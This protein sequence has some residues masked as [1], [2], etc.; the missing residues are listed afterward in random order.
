MPAITRRLFLSAGGGLAWTVLLG[1]GAEHAAAD[2]GPEPSVPRPRIYTRSDWGA[3]APKSKAEVLDTPP[4]RLVIHHTATANTSDQS[5]DAAFRL[6]RAIQRYHM[7]RNG[8]ADIGEQFTVSRGGH[9]MEGRNRTLPAIAKGGHVV[10]AQA[11]GHNRHTLGIETEGTYT[12]ELP[13]PAQL[14]ALTSLLAWLCSTYRLDPE[15]AI[16]GHRDLNATACPGD[17]LY[18]YLPELRARVAERLGTSPPEKKESADSD[19]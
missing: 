18:E 8:W 2:T 13:P 7:R 9:I 17:R 5:L 14:T 11:F 1:S 4:D 15:K 12:A 3:A 19:R 16:I 6:S 10:G